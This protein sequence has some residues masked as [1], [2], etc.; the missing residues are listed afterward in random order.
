MGLVEEEVSL[1]QRLNA[2]S[3][4]VAGKKLPRP[5]S[6]T[7]QVCKLRICIAQ[8][9]HSCDSAKLCG[10]NK[11][12]SGCAES[13]H[14]RLPEHYCRHS[15]RHESAA[16]KT[17]TRWSGRCRSCDEAE[18]PEN[19]RTCRFLSRGILRFMPSTLSAEPPSR[20]PLERRCMAF[21]CHL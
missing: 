4:F 20:V 2:V 7:D 1:T 11:Y 3:S 19:P 16:L 15:R 9:S 8:R 5:G 21:G 14:A 18:E 13:L 6:S 10:E 17:K 12:C